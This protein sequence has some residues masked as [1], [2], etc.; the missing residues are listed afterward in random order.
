MLSAAKVKD[1]NTL[2]HGQ[3]P[4]DSSKAGSDPGKSGQRGDLAYE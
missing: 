4:C 2:G 3:V 1:K